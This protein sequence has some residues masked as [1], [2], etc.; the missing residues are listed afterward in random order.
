MKPH[1]ALHFR[2]YFFFRALSCNYLYYIG[3]TSVLFCMHL[4][5]LFRENVEVIS[6]SSNFSIFSTLPWNHQS[7]LHLL[8]ITFLQKF[9]EIVARSTFYHFSTKI[10]WKHWFYFFCFFFS[11]KNEV[12]EFLS[13][14]F[15]CLQ[16]FRENN[17][18]FYNQFLFEK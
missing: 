6:N 16:K 1:D 8:S 15:F 4:Q 13:F 7:S 12:I 18:A 11:A 17:F 2:L 9:R 3:L 5:E 14:L 10:S